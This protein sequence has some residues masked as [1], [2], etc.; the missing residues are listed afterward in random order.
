MFGQQDGRWYCMGCYTGSEVL[1]PR[2]RGPLTRPPLA[3]PGGCET[4][5]SPRP[6]GQLTGHPDNGLASP[7]R[8]WSSAVATPA[9]IGSPLIGIGLAQ[10]SSPP[11]RVDRLSLKGDVQPGL[12]SPGTPLVAARPGS[13]SPGTPILVARPGA[14]SPAPAPPRPEFI[15]GGAW[16]GSHSPR[17]SSSPPRVACRSPAICGRPGSVSPGMGGMAELVAAAVAC[18]MA[19]HTAPLPTPGPAGAVQRQVSTPF[20]RMQGAQSPMLVVPPMS[21]SQHDVLSQGGAAAAAPL[22]SFGRSRRAPDA[23]PYGDSCRLRQVPPDAAPYGDS[24]RLRVVPPGVVRQL[25]TQQRRPSWEGSVQG[26]K[27]TIAAP[28]AALSPPPPWQHHLGAVPLG[29]PRM[30]LKTPRGCGSPRICP[31]PERAVAAPREL[32]PFMRGFQAVPPSRPRELSPTPCASSGGS[33][34]TRE[35]SPVAFGPRR[36]PPPSLSTV[37][38]AGSAPPLPHATLHPGLL[39]PAANLSVPLTVVPAA[40]CWAAGSASPAWVVAGAA[41]LPGYLP[42]GA[43]RSHPSSVVAPPASS[44]ASMRSGPG[45]ARLVMQ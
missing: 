4:L 29:S 43:C 13:L 14:L 5:R 36:R 44:A 27:T 32:S 31:A 10:G 16:P 15:M 37:T 8:L 12:R 30:S 6:T 35:L 1:P 11:P 41:V 7:W 39:N 42:P 25:S 17:R 26:E 19:P 28:P 3:S 2:V 34:R 21:G 33:L 45:T 18:G 22:E 20:D 24:C 40:P 9:P 38:A 23:A